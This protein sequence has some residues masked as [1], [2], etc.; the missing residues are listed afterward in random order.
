[1]KFILSIILIIT[2]LWLIGQD[3]SVDN[4]KI[5][6]TYKTFINHKLCGY[7]EHDKKGNII[8]SKNNGMNGPITMLYVAEYD[9]LSRRTRSYFVHSNLGFSAI[10]IV[11][12]PLKIKYF[13]F[14]LESSDENSYNRTFLNTVN[15]KK[16][17]ME[18]KETKDLMKGKKELSNIELLDSTNHVMIEYY[19]S[20]KGDTSSINTY[21]YNKDHKEVWFHYGTIGSEDW[22]W[23]IYSIYNDHLD[24]IKSYRVSATNDIRDTTEVYQYIYNSNHQ[25]ISENYYHK[26]KFSHKTDYV[27]N[28]KGQLIKEQFYEGDEAV[29]DV[30]TTYQYDKNTKLVSKK[31]SKDYRN[32]KKPETEVW[33]FKATYW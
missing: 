13:H 25:L 30:I 22:T 9:S 28:E 31:V 24:K 15:S 16:E 8:F 11:F 6:K 3:K 23:D 17:F 26:K 12:E 33:E 14:S 29:I 18:L 5:T 20:E 19:L 27:Y 7:E 21:Q 10:D 2:Q 1:M 32:S 4:S